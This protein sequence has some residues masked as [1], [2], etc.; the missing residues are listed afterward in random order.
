MSHGEVILTFLKQ[1]SSEWFGDDELSERL[2]ITPRQTVNQVCRRLAK[3][4]RIRRQSVGGRIKNGIVGMSEPPPPSDYRVSGPSPIL[5]TTGHDFEGL[6]RRVMSGHFQADLRPGVVGRVPKRFDLVSKDESIVGDAKYFTMVGGDRPP[7]A[8]YSV[9]A[10]YVWLLQN[11][12]AQVKFLVF[13]NDR[14]VPEGW[15]SK[16]G[17]LRKDV[18]FFFL[19][20]MGT[21]DELS[22]E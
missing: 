22:P 18:R 1:N 3:E 9:I 15:L 7:P 16:Y 8:K 12:P 21:L 10:E 20:G 4:G 11:T 14:R 2:H 19:D 17:D 5:E 6:A 13:G